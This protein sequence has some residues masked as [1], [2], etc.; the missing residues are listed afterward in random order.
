M[1]WSYTVI[2]IANEFVQE[3]SIVYLD[4]YLEQENIFKL[5]LEI[6]LAKLLKKKKGTYSKIRV[7]TSRVGTPWNVCLPRAML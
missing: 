7:F 5:A 2:C 6:T 1:S 3:L 4:T